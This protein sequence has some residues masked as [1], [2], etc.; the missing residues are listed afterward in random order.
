[1]FFL[2]S[3]RL[4]PSKTLKKNNEKFLVIGSNLFFYLLDKNKEDQI[5][6]TLLRLNLKKK[7]TIASRYLFIQNYINTWSQKD[8][9][10]N[11]KKLSIYF[12]KLETLDL[13]KINF[14]QNKKIKIGFVSKDLYENHPL[15][16]FVSSIFKYWDK[17][18]FEIY[19]Y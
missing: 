18:L 11:A 10:Q 6:K 2:F 15:S 1:M 7:D 5:L 4:L 17:D 19:V 9:Y 3:S 16:Y 12:S 14:D 13:K 8:H